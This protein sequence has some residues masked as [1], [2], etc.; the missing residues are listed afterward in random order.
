VS[1]P[2]R[3]FVAL[4]VV[5]ALF[6]HVPAYTGGVGTWLD[7]LT[8]FAVAAA[9]A[10]GLSNG[11]RSAVVVGIAAV[12]L[13]VDGHGIHL[14]ANA[15]GHE[16]VGP[17]ESTV[18]FWDEHWGH[19]EWHLGW[20][21]LLA[22]LSLADSATPPRPNDRPLLGLGGALLGS[23]VL[24]GFTLFTSTVEGQDWW[25][26]LAV[27]PVFA[28]WAATRRGAVLAASATATLLAAALIGI[29]AAWHGGVPEFSDLGW[30]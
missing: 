23:A 26:T 16:D 22:A 7:L 2:A 28:V 29:W 5:V 11:P 25:L 17:A 3:A 20:L 6:H 19:A 9:A 4:A 1:R 18:E 8:P 12:V 13:Y 24:T 21:G 15:I 10:Y 27:A 30:L 14:A